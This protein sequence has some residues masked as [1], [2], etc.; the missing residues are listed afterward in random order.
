VEFRI[1]GPV[2][3]Y[4]DG[5]PC[6][7]GSPKE[8]GVLAVLLYHLG[9]PVT[10]DS[11]IAHLWGD[12]PPARA[13]SALYSHISRLRTSLRRATGDG[14]D[15]LA[16]RSG[17][18]L[19]VGEE[20][21][22][23]WRFRRLRDQA[24]SAA[25]HGDDKSVA[26][27]L[28]EAEELWRGTPLAGV[29]GAW[30]DGIR[31]SLEEDRFAVRIERIEA[32]LRLDR[33][34]DL[35]GEIRGLAT[36]RPLDEKLARL[37]MLALDGC[38]RRAEALAAY[39]D[40]RQ[41]FA[42]E[43]GSEPGTEL[44]QLHMRMLSEDPAPTVPR[45]RPPTYAPT[46]TTAQTDRPLNT[47][48]RDHPHFTGRVAELDAIRCWL[49]PE[50]EQSAVS[51]I[52]I[53][54]MAG[55][56]KTALAVRAAHLHRERYPDQFYLALRGN[57]PDG[58][59]VAPVSAL[60][61]L[62][63]ML[64]VPDTWIPDGV[65]DRASL[66]RSLLAGRRALILLDD[67]LD[68]A[69]V[70][71]LLP[72]APG[73]AVLVTTRRRTIDLP[74]M[75]WLPLASMRPPE[76]ASLFTWTAGE[77][78]TG[79][80]A[81]VASV[82][83]LCGY[84]PLEI[85][86]AASELRRHPAW[87]AGDL[88]SRLREADMGDRRVARALELSYRHLRTAQQRLFRLLAL[89][90][91]PGFSRQAAVAMAEGEPLAETERTLGVLLD[92]HLIEESAPD[93]YT[94]HDLVREYAHDL[95]ET[96]DTAADR[97]RARQRLLDYYLWLVGEAD[98]IVYPFHRRTD[99]RL[100]HSPA[101]LPRPGTRRE[102]QQQV[103]A[104]L[105]SLFPLARYAVS[106]G[107]ARHVGMLSQ[108]LARFLDTWGYWAHAADLHSLAATAWRSTGNTRGQARAQTDRSFIL[109]RLGRYGE[110]L[111]CASEALTLAQAAADRA[112]QAEAL[113]R[114]GIALWRLARYPE[115]LG[116]FEEA[117]A[118]WRA[119]GDHDGEADALCHSA[120][121]L[122]HVSSY[123]ESFRR[124]EQALAIYRQIGD[125][126]G[127]A[128]AL[129]NLADLLQE[130]GC[131]EQ[132]LASYQQ[133]LDMF[134]DLGDR[135]GEAIAVHNIGIICGKAGRAEEA[136]AHYRTA[137]DIYRDIGDRRDEADA[138]DNMGTAFQQL[139]HYGDALLHH[140]MA[141]VL[142]HEIAERFL[143]ARSHYGSGDAHLASRNYGAAADDYQTAIEV[144]RKIADR[145]QEAQALRGLGNV[146]LYTDGEKTARIRWHEALRIFEAIGKPDEA[147]GIR[148]LLRAPVKY[149]AI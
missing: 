22:D 134:R 41:H 45:A 138:L 106:Q 33:H 19:N 84:L 86:I 46:P 35:V 102:A 126:H 14:R 77:G 118:I 113:D 76:A 135:Q 60:S 68:A 140:Q 29:G 53:E 15:W 104:E 51:V 47:M 128:T 7:L 89:H 96:H 6:G 31:I 112:A 132:A 25:D 149:E 62:L 99:A 110:A 85:E 78:R 97:D 81:S 105:P 87:D 36:Q 13:L 130:A 93:R 90:P 9:R 121:A 103:A 49:T 127:E 27:L 142:A 61:A 79:D 73:C 17:Y 139:G 26:E 30:A 56:G 54:G 43:S 122:W 69:Q 141:L 145:Y 67:A 125:L 119:L 4:I 55:V 131:P 94:F 74:G 75:F 83:R 100:P 52:V 34:A 32:E 11:L 21:V 133:A 50:S 63:R 24:R 82:L 120:L 71:P 144:S 111:E 91:A 12:D 70:R 129:N 88:A 44:Q 18:L 107:H 42:A 116:R 28:R 146:A 114:M 64:G 101:N 10:A 115:A 40:F 5:R 37:L 92:H 148:A 147:A 3:L 95:A 108:V 2:D 20:S 98:R 39:L 23:Y 143:E 109:Q 123:A 65:E 117:L 59:P 124:A 136:L 72:G 38:G 57:A 137:L 58:D 48:L 1:L 66:W 16:R 80:H 8:R